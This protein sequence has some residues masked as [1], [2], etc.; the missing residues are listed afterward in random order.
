MIALPDGQVFLNTTG[1]EGMATGG[2][3]DV[4]TGTIAALLGQGLQLGQAACC[5]VYLHGM[6]G[7]MAAEAGKIGLAAG[8]LV[9]R[10]PAALKKVRKG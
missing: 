8:D 7:D 5:G 1:N 4:L 9:D 3:G 6:A 10:L 2:C